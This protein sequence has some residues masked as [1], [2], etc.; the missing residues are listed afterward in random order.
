MICTM[1]TIVAVGI[2]FLALV[3]AIAAQEQASVASQQAGLLITLP[4]ASS[5]ILGSNFSIPLVATGGSA[6]YSWHLVDGQLPP[7]LK[8]HPHKGEISGTP[9][10]PGEY[11]FTIA[12]ADSSVPQIQIQRAVTITVIAG[13]TVDWKQPP[14]VQGTILSGSAVVTNQTGRDF[15]LTVVIVAVNSIGRATTLGYQHVTLAG[16]KSSPVIPFS[17]SPGP[18]KYVVHADAVAHHPGGHHIYRARK[19]TSEPLP[20]TEN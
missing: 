8:L 17:S 18:G 7:G 16:E 5:A 1:R 11:R 15:D 19:Q 13:L 4:P 12:V 9:T 14:K 20:I 3:A 6:P 10:T 2:V